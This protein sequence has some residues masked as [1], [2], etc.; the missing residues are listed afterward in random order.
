MSVWGN[1][2]CP[3][4][5]PMHVTLMSTHHH[6]HTDMHPSPT[7]L[8]VQQLQF[9][10][11]NKPCSFPLESNGCYQNYFLHGY[12]NFDRLVHENM[13][14]S[15][16]EGF[17]KTSHIIIIIKHYKVTWRI[18]FI[19]KRTIHDTYQNYMSQRSNY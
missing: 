17:P 6:S 9:T 8:A 2:V 5:A 18:K 16:M 11:H 14:T 3:E 19:R 12:I 1:R 4:C 7:P 15:L 10:S 13:F